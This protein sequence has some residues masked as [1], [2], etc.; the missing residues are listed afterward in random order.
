MPKLRPSI[1]TLSHRSTGESGSCFSCTTAHLLLGPQQPD[2]M[3]RKRRPPAQYRPHRAC[4]R[5]WLPLESRVGRLHRQGRRHRRPFRRCEPRKQGRRCRRPRPWDRVPRVGSLGW[6]A[7][8]EAR[9]GSCAS[10][11]LFLVSIDKLSLL[12]NCNYIVCRSDAQKKHLILT[13][14]VSDSGR[15]L[16]FCP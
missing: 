8:R 5:R 12:S 2:V 15:C 1:R 11:P 4:I 16:L 7:R 14:A 9:Q 10:L 6:K 3:G 13:S